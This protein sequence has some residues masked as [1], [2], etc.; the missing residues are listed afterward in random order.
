VLGERLLNP[1]VEG[2]NPSGPTNISRRLTQRCVGRL[3]FGVLR[4]AGPRGSLDDCI[5]VELGKPI[6]GLCSEIVLRPAG[7][8]PDWSA[9]P[10][11]ARAD[12]VQHGRQAGQG[13]PRRLLAVLRTEQWRLLHGIGCACLRGRLRERLRGPLVRPG[14]GHHGLPI[15]V[16]PFESTPTWATPTPPK[17]SA[18]RSLPPRSPGR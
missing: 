2:S 11:A 6:D 14:S 9:L 18:S 13:L 16:Q 17:C 12:R 1:L 7:F 4:T 8:S 5:G 3:S 10:L 15:L